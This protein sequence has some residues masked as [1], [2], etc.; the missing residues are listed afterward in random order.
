M[1]IEEVIA[2]AAWPCAFAAP[3][4]PAN[5]AKAAAAA[6][7]NNLV[8]MRVS[9][10]RCFGLGGRRRGACSFAGAGAPRYP[11]SDIGEFG[12]L[13]PWEQRAVAVKSGGDDGCN[14]GA[15]S[16]NGQRVEIGVFL[17]CL[18]KFSLE[19][20]SVELDGAELA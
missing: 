1:V 5:V 9:P 16:I 10:S 15:R 3:I 7:M 8:D 2:V 20:S 17:E 19:C 12:R 6:I 4:P 18:F 13:F 11:K 14:L